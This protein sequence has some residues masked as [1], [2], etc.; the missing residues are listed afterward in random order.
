MDN[1]L[2][3]PPPVRLIRIHFDA[4]LLPHDPISRS[5][6]S[7]TEK[8]DDDRQATM[9]VRLRAIVKKKEHRIVQTALSYLREE[10][11]NLK[12]LTRRLFN[13]SAT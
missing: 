11:W 9:I 13:F 2:F 6:T 10:Q 7:A 12:G 4:K 5:I 1:L 3:T 8:K